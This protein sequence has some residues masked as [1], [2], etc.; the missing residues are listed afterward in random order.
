MV[1][2]FSGRGRSPVYK[3]VGFSCANRRVDHLASSYI[4]MKLALHRKRKADAQFREEK[5]GRDRRRCAGEDQVGGVTVKL[6]RA[7]RLAGHS[8]SAAVGGHYREFENLIERGVILS[9]GAELYVLRAELKAVTERGNSAHHQPGSRRARPYHASASGSQMDHR[10][11][12]RCSRQAGDE[13]DYPPVQN[14]E[15][16]DPSPILARILTQP[17]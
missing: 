3:G 13:T 2:S 17:P 9:Q 10:R 6:A 15:A 14:A 7:L 16:R 5:G 4:E 8:R 11:S 1:T 12:R